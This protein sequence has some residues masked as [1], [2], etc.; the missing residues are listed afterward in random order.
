M[1]ELNV[2]VAY[3][4][5]DQQVLIDVSLPSGATVADAIQRSAII[6]RFPQLDRDD[7]MLGVWGRPATAETILKDGD[8]VEIYRKL[9]LEPREARRQLADVGRTMRRKTPRG[10]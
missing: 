1:A 10:G 3:A 2:E 7:L 9:L 8:R 5:P 4:E 6:N